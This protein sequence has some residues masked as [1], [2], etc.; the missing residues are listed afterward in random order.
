V[1]PAASPIG[2]E[3]EGEVERDDEPA[4]CRCGHTRSHHMVSPAKEYTVGGY[5]LL[6]FGITA[7][8]I[9][10]R[11]VCRTCEQQIETET[12]DTSGAL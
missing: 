3:A 11:Y 6:F 7:K 2:A 9:R 4:R 12:L 10:I 5:L 8:P 1:S